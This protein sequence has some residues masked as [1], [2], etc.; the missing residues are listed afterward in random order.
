MI[1]L[2]FL[3][4]IIGSG[5]NKT[6]FSSNTLLV[7]SC[8]CNSVDGHVILKIFFEKNFQRFNL[9]KFNFG[10]PEILS[11]NFVLRLNK[12]NK[13]RGN[14]VTKCPIKKLGL[15]LIKNLHKGIIEKKNMTK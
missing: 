11:I 13:I 2:K 4:S 10:K 6:F 7:T 14:D 12:L 9:K 8:F 5:R 3:I 15:S 1:F